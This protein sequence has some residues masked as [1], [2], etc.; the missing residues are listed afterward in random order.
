MEINKKQQAILYILGAY[1]QF[2]FAVDYSSRNRA[3]LIAG[4]FLLL[5]VFLVFALSAKG[6]VILFSKKKN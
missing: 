2:L 5:S 1:A 3:N 4:L 6:L